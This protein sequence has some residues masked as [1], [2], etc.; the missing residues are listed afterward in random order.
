MPVLPNLI[1]RFSRSEAPVAQSVNTRYLYRFSGSI[2]AVKIPASYFLDVDKLIKVYMGR[3]KTQN[4]QHNIK[5]EE[6]WRTN[7]T[8]L[9][10]L[11]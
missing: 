5:G 3:Q 7:T 6:S 8:K 4:T 10:D 9:Q 11:L 2:D 1:Y